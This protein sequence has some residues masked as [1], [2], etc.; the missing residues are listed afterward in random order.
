[1]KFSEVRQELA[2]TIDR[3]TQDCIPILITRSGGKPAAVLLSLAE[4][5]SLVETQHLL[6]SEANIRQLV[7]ALRD[8]SD[9]LPAAE[10]GKQE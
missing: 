7:E 2:A 9:G 10:V 3:T 1:M 6:G 5:E 8:L 4:Y